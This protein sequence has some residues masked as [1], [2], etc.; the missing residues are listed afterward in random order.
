MKKPPET[1]DNHETGFPMPLSS[2]V[3]VLGNYF[4]NLFLVTGDNET[5][6]FET[7]ISGIT[8]AV[9]SQLEALGAAPDYLIMSHP[10]SDHAT[11]LPGL[12]ARFPD[13]VVLAGEGAR[14][15]IT[16]PKA[17]PLMLAEDAFMSKGLL[18]RG[19]TPGRPPI[20][21][22]P[23]LSDARAVTNKT[24]LDLGGVTL[25]LKPVSGHSP[26]NII[27]RVQDIVF[28]SDSLGFHFPGRGFW[29]L[30]FT[31]VEAYL[32]T[33][34][35]IQDLAP[36]VI[37]PAHQGPLKNDAAAG[38]IQAAIDAT[39]S[40]IERVTRTRLSDQ[41]L[42]AQLLAESYRDEFTLYTKENIANCNQLL[43][44]RARQFAS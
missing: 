15:F 24:V 23:D 42:F 27:A 43:V 16:H 36:A 32:S 30:F 29:P 18:H 38:G 5:A 11:G 8:D 2:R 22:V 35:Y 4:I 7:G 40:F 10:H 3:I 44:K 33:Q 1:A 12:M 25:E 6:L 31:G 17:G 34:A 37:C 41:K 21:T 13:A 19:I 26:G 20:D 39:H 28:C 14:E 9:I